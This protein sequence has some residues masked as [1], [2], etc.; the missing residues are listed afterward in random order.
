MIIKIVVLILSAIVQ[1]SYQ[2]QQQQ[3]VMP[4]P[5]GALQQNILQFLQTLPSA[6]TVNYL[7]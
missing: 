2:Q 4:N 3:T 7:F 1:L 5:P 6:Q